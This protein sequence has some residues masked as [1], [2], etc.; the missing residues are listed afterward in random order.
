MCPV[1]VYNVHNVMYIP[2]KFITERSIFYVPLSYETPGHRK[3]SYIKIRMLDGTG[4]ILLKETQ[5]RK[6]GSP[7]EKGT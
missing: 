4:D 7:A 6:Y 1:L 2:T 3:H 5:R